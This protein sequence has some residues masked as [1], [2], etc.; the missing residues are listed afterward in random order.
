VVLAGLPGGVGLADVGCETTRARV[1][2]SRAIA[3]LPGGVGGV[4][5]DVRRPSSSLDAPPCA[6]A[7]APPC[8]A[9][10]A[11]AGVWLGVHGLWLSTASGALPLR[12]VLGALGVVGGGDF[13]AVSMTNESLALTTPRIC[14]HERD[15]Q[16][17]CVSVYAGER[18]LV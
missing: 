14:T 2:L 4:N 16:V 8:A 6:A 15:A 9:A 5:K 7:D 13:G 3:G 12:G 18:G 1:G 11:P 17:C 10:D